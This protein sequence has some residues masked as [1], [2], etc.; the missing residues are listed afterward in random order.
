M[1]PV[2][3]P[4]AIDDLAS[5]RAFIAEQDPAAA[6]RVVLRIIHLV[7]TLA[8]SPEMGRP[9]RVPGTRELVITRTPFIVPYR[10]QGQT[11]QILR[12]YHGARRWPDHF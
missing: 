8:E 1:T 7:E 3:T 11:I 4:A 5:L 12:V 10:L 9:G 2:W 6:Q